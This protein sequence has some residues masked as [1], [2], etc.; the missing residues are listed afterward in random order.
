MKI[1]EHT[2]APN[3]LNFNVQQ[4]WSTNLDH[5]AYYWRGYRRL[6][7]HWEA[8]TGLRMLDVHY[9]DT[10]SEIN[11]SAEKMLSFLGLSWHDDVLEFYKN[12]RAVQTPSR[13]QVRQPVYKSSVARWQNYGDK[14]QPLIEAQESLL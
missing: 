10:V 1:C 7:Q 4:K 14:L 8:V 5:I 12:Q 11:I 9:E 13:W 3:L 6:M 2:I